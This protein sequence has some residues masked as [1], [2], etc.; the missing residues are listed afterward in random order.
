VEKARIAPIKARI[1]RLLEKYFSGEKMKY[2]QIFG[3]IIPILTDQAFLIVMS[4]LNIAMI[5]SAG[6]AAISAVNMVDSLNIFLV[7]VFIAIATGGTVIIAQYIGS[8]NRENAAKT[9]TQSISVSTLFSVLLCIL[10]VCFHNPLLTLL[11]GRAEPDV[12]QN[13]KIYLIGSCISYPFIAIFESVRSSLIGIGE[14]KGSLIL[15]LIMNFINTVLNLVFITMLHMS[16]LG[17]VISIILARIIGMVAALI[18]MVKNNNILRLKVKNALKLEFSI[19]KKIMLIGF[20]FALEQMFFNGGKLLTQTFIVKLGTYALAV[21]A[22][23]GSITSLYQIAPS[24]LSIAIVS[25]VGQCIGQ[26]NIMDAKKFTKSFIGLSTIFFIVL[27]LIIFPAFPLLMKMFGAPKTITSDIFM[28]ILMSAFAQPIFWSISFILPSSLRAAGDAK[29]TSITSMLSMWLFRVVLGYVLGIM[30]HFGIVGVWVA[31]F[32]EWGV[33]S[34]FFMRRFHGE[35]WY[36]HKL[37]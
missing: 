8:G 3:I 11:F 19:I 1:A 28:I 13:A 16:I 18:Y 29:F 7:N 22:I 21:N 34:I 9:A 35:K 23:S 6:V 20:P 2:K 14:S 31:M 26:K 4:L 24:S 12:L 37:I 25:V 36:K 5:S 27:S 32:L 15:S 10:I 33:R 17:L 30:L